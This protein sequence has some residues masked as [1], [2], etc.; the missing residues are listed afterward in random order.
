MSE[1]F[2]IEFEAFFL[3]RKIYSSLPHK[4]G[5]FSFFPVRVITATV[6]LAEYWKRFTIASHHY[7]SYS[8]VFFFFIQDD[9]RFK[10]KCNLR[11]LLI[12]AHFKL[13][14]QFILY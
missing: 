10:K 5:H 2:S 13:F 8:F 1:D 7:L 11:P 4:V 12:Y 3:P 6:A 14:T 9:T